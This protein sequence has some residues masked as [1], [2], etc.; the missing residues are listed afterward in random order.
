MFAPALSH[1]QSEFLEQ[2]ARTYCRLHNTYSEKFG[3]L[4]SKKVI[5]IADCNHLTRASNKFIQQFLSLF[6]RATDCV[7]IEGLSAGYTI[8]PNL[9]P[10]WA[11]LPQDITIRGSDIRSPNINSENFSTWLHKKIE[12]TEIAMGYR[13]AAKQMVKQVA[14]QLNSLWQDGRI[15]LTDYIE[16]PKENLSNFRSLS[17]GFFNLRMSLLCSYQKTR[18]LDG[19]TTAVRVQSSNKGLLHEI[20]R[21]C[22]EEFSCVIIYWG[23]WH[24]EYADSIYDSLDSLDI[25]H[26]TIVANQRVHEKAHQ[27]AAWIKEEL[28]C[29]SL[30]LAVRLG[31]TERDCMQFSVPREFIPIFQPNIQTYFPVEYKETAAE[32][33]LDRKAFLE[34][35]EESNCLLPHKVKFLKIDPE[36]LNRM[37]DLADITDKVEQLN[38]FRDCA[39]SC[40]NNWLLLD[41]KRISETT[42]M[43]VTLLGKHSFTLESLEPIKFSFR[44]VN[45]IVIAATILLREMRRHK[46]ASWKLQPDQELLFID[47]SE[48]KRDEIVN[49][50]NNIIPWLNSRTPSCYGVNLQ[51]SSVLQVEPVRLQPANQKAIGL[52]SDKEVIFTLTKKTS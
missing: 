21:A 3:K 7:L 10:G 47:L 39:I 43:N 36:H 30:T 37:R 27:E 31:V 11:H 48:K 38:L 35:C 18:T 49:Q 46:L 44:R 4:L 52:R 12:H 40:L 45:Q 25:P 2:N 19:E 22:S 9:I 50:P 41:G 13:K 5:F 42:M 8:C 15:K 28:D 34:H 23:E 33:K 24:V 32:L 6:G 14:N 26:M 1:C 17:E 16:M 20:L 51:G 29:S